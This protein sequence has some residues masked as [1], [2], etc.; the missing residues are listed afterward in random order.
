MQGESE[1]GGGR[2]QGQGG[3]VG[4]QV[5]AEEVGV[6]R[7]LE[8]VHP[9]VRGGVGEV[10][11]FVQGAVGE[12]EGEVWRVTSLVWWETLQ[13]RGLGEDPV[14]GRADCAQGQLAQEGSR[15][16]EVLQVGVDQ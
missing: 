2:V 13:A 11:G 16:H 5:Q 4:G 1:V 10:G 7:G 8:E 15:G 6:D 9:D 3:V 12:W 14:L